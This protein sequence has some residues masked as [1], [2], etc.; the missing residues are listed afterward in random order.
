M[1]TARL[2]CRGLLVALLMV[3]SFPASAERWMQVDTH[4]L[5]LTVMDDDRPQLTLHNLAIGRNG[6]GRDRRRGDETTPLG[7]FRV[8]RIDRDATFH[9][10]IGLSYPDAGRARRALYEGIITV[11]Q[12][13][14]ILAAHQR[15]AA[16]PQ[17]TALGGHIGIHGL[18]RADPDVHR[19]MNWTKGCVALTNEQIDTLLLWVRV[20]MTVE[21]R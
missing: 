15:G 21:I 20:G 2:L 17:D 3:L 8:T 9:R 4:Q 14:A 5:T 11:D 12:H 18:G 10:F 19:L 13:R 1:T 16:P 7:R 6:V